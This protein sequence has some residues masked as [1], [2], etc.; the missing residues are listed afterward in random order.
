MSRIGRQPI[1]LPAGVTVEVKPGQIVQVHGP[2]G[3]LEEKIARRLTVEQENGVVRVVRHGNSQDLR[4]LHG[5]ARALISN[6]VTGVTEG[7][8]RVLEVHG[9]FYRA[10]MKGRTL[11]LQV[12]KSHPVEYPSSDEIELEVDGT[13]RVITLKGICKQDVGQL[14]AVI[15][16]ERPPEPYGGSG[17]RYRGEWV[18]SKAGKA[19]RAGL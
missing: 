5:L 2:K 8:T 6:M 12:G 13:G 9:D 14:A 7:Y 16:A 4:A 3:A 11:V 1:A 10:S 18:R 19:G 17:I 15:R